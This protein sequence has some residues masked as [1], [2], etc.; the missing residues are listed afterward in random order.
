MNIN[1]VETEYRSL[2]NLAKTEFVDLSGA[3]LIGADLSG[4]DLSDAD[5]SG[6]DLSGADLSGA[7]LSGS[8]M[9]VYQSGAWTAYITP[10][11]IRIGC[12]FHETRAWRHFKDKEIGKMSEGALDYWIENKEIILS[13]ADSIKLKQDGK[14]A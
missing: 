7:N 13:I 9:K 3:D 2:I 14:A 5:L 4:A 11:H 10:S 12:Q 1:T 6:A 8:N